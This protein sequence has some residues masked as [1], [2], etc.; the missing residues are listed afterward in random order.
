M[1]LLVLSVFAGIALLLAASGLYG[2][3]AHAVTERTHEIGV[4]M[5]LGAERGDVIQLVVASGMSMTV[6]GVLLGIG[7][8]AA[9]TK[10]LEGLLFGVEPMDP[11]TFGAVGAMLIAVSAVAC[12]LPA[13]RAT[14]IP[15][16][17]ALRAE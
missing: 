11:I 15:P 16:V 9:V 6:A 3:V 2:L 12:W 7:G 14:R 5:A 13:W 8:A 17:T 4:R 10:Y 1:A